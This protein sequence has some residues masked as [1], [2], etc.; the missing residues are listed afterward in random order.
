MIGAMR[1][2]QDTSTPGG[3][4][5][6]DIRHIVL[7]GDALEGLLRAREHGSLE[8]KLVPGGQ[9]PWKLT[10][11]PAGNAVRPAPLRDL[12]D[13]ATHIVISIEGNRAI[14][15]S[16]LLSAQRVSYEE[17]LAKL[18]LAADQFE[19]VIEALIRA[20]QATGL[21]MV[22]CTMWRPRYTEPQRQRAAVA[23]LAIFNECIYRR[24]VAARISV[25]DLCSVC[26]E[27]GDYSNQTL[28]S[29]TGLRKGANAVWRALYAVSRG[30]PRTEVF[31]S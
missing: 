23:A 28:L 27:L 25:V 9:T 4:A 17:A 11:L 26:A 10:M 6:G 29:K 31:S 20:A 2:D 14:E 16:E 7:I 1:P 3:N 21:P 12:P 30:G 5:P 24:A 13:D 18:S 15:R 22:I 8:D 19:G